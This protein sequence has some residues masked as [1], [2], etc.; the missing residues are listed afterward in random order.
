LPAIDAEAEY[1]GRYVA[2]QRYIRT[3][4]R[5]IGARYP[6]ALAGFPYID[7]H[8]GFPYS[9]F[10]GPGGAQYN[11]PQMYWLDIGTGVD[12]VYSHTYAYNR[13]YE[14]PIS[15]L[16]QI[17]NRPPAGEIRRFRQLSRNYGAPGVSWWDW[18]EGT[19]GA[20]HAVSQP[21]GSL[22]SLAADPSLAVLREGA[23]GDVVVWAQEHLVSA[24]QQVGIDGSFG[25]ATKAAVTSF[26]LS[27]GLL[28]A[29]G[30]IGALTWHALLRYRPASVTWTHGGARAASAVG[31]GDRPVPASASLP[32][33]RNEIPRS[34]GAGRP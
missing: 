11:V 34:L 29:S 12:R 21:I 22:T 7:Y 26:Q 25:S 31:A 3:L 13:L 16:G 10:M 33:V 32:A 24:G 4:R 27:K 18:Q 1:E 28:P 19:G 6:V 14:R 2:A 23:K 30:T 20:W 17:Y 9:V 8:P 15:P 5:L